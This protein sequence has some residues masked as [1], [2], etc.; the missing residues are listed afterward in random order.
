MEKHA[1]NSIIKRPPIVVIMG[2]IDH[3]KSTLLDY[4]RKTNIVDT[5]VGGITQR[6]SA[7]EVAHKMPQGADERITFLDTP[8][9]EAFGFMRTCGASI[10]DV[11]VLVVSA[12]EGVKKQ[13]LEA[14]KCI[15][16]SKIPYI[17]AI[18]KIDR[19][20]ANVEKTINSLIE[21]EIY[22]EGYGGNIP[23]VRIS[24]KTGQGV[25][26]LLDMILLVAEMQELKGDTKKLAEGLVIEA[27]MDKQKGITAILVIRDGH[28]G[29]GMFVVSGDRISPTRMMESFLGKKIT[30]AILSSPI[31]II[32]FD[33]L[34][35]AGSNFITFDTKKE[36]EE[37]ILKEKE[38]E[39]HIPIKNYST[40]SDEVDPNLLRIMIKTE[41]AGSIHAVEHEIDKI[42]KDTQKIK[43]IGAGT[44]NVSENDVKLASGKN[45]AVIVGFDV[46]I[47]A[48]AK[49]LAE[50]SGIEIQ[51]FDIIY[52]IAEWMVEEVEKRTPKVMVEEVTAEIKVL[53][54]FSTMKDK[55]ILGA[56][57]EKGTVF[58]GEEAKIMRDGVEIG[59]GK[60]RDLQKEKNKVGEIR[61][62]VEFGCQFQSEIEPAPG[63]KILIFK[64]IEK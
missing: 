10:A 28:I 61:E 29:T 26:E 15:V 14:L 35:K 64:T 22:L 17:V 38:K 30:E 45:K 60:I 16:D 6:I 19:P 33:K 34:P 50:R 2:H 24:A 31:R 8:G 49:E 12:E 62:G 21:N 27:H 18:N 23:Y 20:G 37:Y 5:E 43:I 57:A 25:P 41:A 9:H 40:D 56:R 63:D 52:K 39:K 55:H 36:A 51:T 48:S 32:G 44:G 54:H 47:D 59:R 11:A 7:Y 3:G 42:N 53:K 13:T 58:V 1:K 4:I 46:G